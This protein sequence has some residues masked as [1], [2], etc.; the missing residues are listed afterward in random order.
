V[1]HYPD[2]R[3]RRVASAFASRYGVPEECVAVGNGSAELIGL[4]YQAAAARRIVVCPP[5]FSLYERLVPVWAT[6]VEVRRIEERGFALDVEGLVGTL[7]AGD[8]AIF[9]NPAN[10]SGAAVEADEVRRLARRAA[11]VGATLIVDEAFADFAPRLTV[12]GSVGQQGLVVLRSLTKFYGIPGLRLGILCAEPEF[13]RRVEALQIPWSVN[14]AA[15]ICGEHCLRDPMWAERSREYLGRAREKLLR[16][17]QQIPGFTVL[18][19]EANYFLVRLD[20][21]APGADEL[22]EKLRAVGTLIRHCG[23]FGLGDRYVRLAVRTV[24]E[25]ANLIR[26]LKKIIPAAGGG[27]TEPRP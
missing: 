5:D 6:A 23:S 2:R 17:L 3:S 25:N 24:A 16:D 11:E 8:A 12:L 20:P 7:R 4:A 18:P 21:P 10:P 22:F 9:S 1:L 26:H 14:A 13:A 27:G 19:S 15:Q